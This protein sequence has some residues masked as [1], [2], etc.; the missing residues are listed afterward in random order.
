MTIFLTTWLALGFLNW[1]RLFIELFEH[2]IVRP[3]LIELIMFM[4]LGPIPLI[5]AL[6]NQEK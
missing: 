5:H 1:L 4:V 2:R 3:K 6:F